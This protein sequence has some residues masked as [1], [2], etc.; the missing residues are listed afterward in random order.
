MLTK[1]QLKLEIR[2]LLSDAAFE[3]EDGGGDR[4]PNLI[5][6]DAL[7][8]KILTLIDEFAP[9]EKELAD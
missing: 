8:R 1:E 4:F 2:Q 6:W 5:N 9:D 3:N 7:E